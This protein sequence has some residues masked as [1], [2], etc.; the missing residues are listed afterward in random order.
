MKQ[1]VKFNDSE[2]TAAYFAKL[3]KFL[4]DTVM[5]VRLTV[6]NELNAFRVFETLND[7]GMDLSAIDLLKNY[8]FGLAFEDSPVCLGQMEHRWSQANQDTY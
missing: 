4:R 2:A 1:V 7:R 3:I 5:V 8:M 6:P